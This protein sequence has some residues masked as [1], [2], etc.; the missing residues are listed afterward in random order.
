VSLGFNR[1]AMTL[2]PPN[3]DTASLLNICGERAAP[4]S[5]LEGGGVFTSSPGGILLK[6]PGAE[7]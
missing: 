5:L 1:L 4:R 3:Q 2:A 6:C 7:F